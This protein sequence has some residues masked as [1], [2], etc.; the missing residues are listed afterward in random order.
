MHLYIHIIYFKS[1][2][3]SLPDHFETLKINQISKRL[4][5]LGKTIWKWE[6]CGLSEIKGLCSV[7]MKILLCIKKKLYDF[8]SY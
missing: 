4:Y 3:S 1:H 5:V 2:I 6:V 7:S 8:S